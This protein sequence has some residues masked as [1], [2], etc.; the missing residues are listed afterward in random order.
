M[1]AKQHARQ[2]LKLD[3]ATILS[4]GIVFA[5]MSVFFFVSSILPEQLNFF[6]KVGN[7]LA[8]MI[9]VPVFTSCREAFLAKTSLHHRA[10]ASSVQ[11]FT[12]AVVAMLILSFLLEYFN[13]VS[14]AQKALLLSNLRGDNVVL[15]QASLDRGNYGDGVVVLPLLFLAAIA[16]GWIIHSKGIVRPALCIVALVGLMTVYRALYLVFSP[17]LQGIVRGQPFQFAVALFVF[18]VVTVIGSAV[19]YASRALWTTIAQ[20]FKMQKSSRSNRPTVAGGRAAKTGTRR[21]R[22]H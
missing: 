13:A 1:S 22:Q 10:D 21:A 19:G 3:R 12:F 4:A 8:P 5:V 9:C 11:F 17:T 18:P 16:V 15:E 2:S 6:S 14:V 20:L 7:I